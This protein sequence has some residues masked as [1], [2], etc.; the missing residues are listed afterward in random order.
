MVHETFCVIV[1]A[2][3]ADATANEPIAA[4]TA[5]RPLR[6]E[7]C[8]GVLSSLV[9][10]RVGNSNGARRRARSTMTHRLATVICGYA[11]M[12][13]AFPSRPSERR[14]ARGSCNLLHWEVDVVGHT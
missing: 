4:R 14:G 11:S 6:R 2:D 8:M 10:S 3:A 7:S 13:C 1:L 5:I 12:R 9:G